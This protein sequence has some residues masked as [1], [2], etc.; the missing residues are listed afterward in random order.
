MKRIHKKCIYSLMIIVLSLG[1]ILPTM[2]QMSSMPGQYFFNQYQ[3][4]AALAGADSSLSMAMSYSKQNTGLPGAPVNAFISVDGFLGKR[5]GLGLNILN[6]KAGLFNQ[7]RVAL[8][9]AYHLPVA[10]GKRLSFG[11]SAAVGN[12]NIYL[13]EAI[14]D[15]DDGSLTDYNARSIYW[16]FDFG[17][18]YVAN[19]LTVQAVVPSFRNHLI[20]DSYQ[21]ADRPSF[22]SSASYKFNLGEQVNSIEP[23]LCY[24]QFKDYPNV[25]DFGF[26]MRFAKTVNLQALYHTT[27]NYSLGMGVDVLSRFKVLAM[28][29]SQAGELK[30][31]SDGGLSLNLRVKLYKAN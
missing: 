24:T 26:D 7:T 11:L 14:G 27:N 20:K 8:S 13:D 30:K 25:W 9:Y 23:K 6:Q 12:G 5:V 18:A 1:T 10:E 3:A 16:D 29:T 15:Q 22:F 28:Y 21:T 2:A 31:Y 19:G 17:L 4:N